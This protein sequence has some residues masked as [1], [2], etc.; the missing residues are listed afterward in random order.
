MAE[1]IGHD[2]VSKYVAIQYGMLVAGVILLVLATWTWYKNWSTPALAACKTAHAACV[3]AVV[4]PTTSSFASKAPGKITETMLHEGFMD[5]PEMPESD[6]ESY[7]PAR[8]SLDQSVFDSHKEFV[9]ESYSS[10][11]GPNSANIERDDTNEVVKRVGLRRVDYTSVYSS[12]DSRTVSSEYP[13]QVAQGTG[14]TD[15]SGL[16]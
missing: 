3:A 16:F 13:E 11:Q 4:A 5:G 14:P 12:D 9:D 7:D 10:T 8:L 15:D 1:L 6:S 2:L